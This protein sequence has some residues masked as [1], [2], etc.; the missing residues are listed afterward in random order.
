MTC[1]STAAL[2][3]AELIENYGR[4]VTSICRRMFRDEESARDAAQEV[5][6]EVV[7][8]LPS[9]RGDSKLS[10]WIYTIAYRVAMHHARRERTYST[11]FL[12]DF[13]RDGEW[14]LPDQKDFDKAVWVKQMCDRCLTGILHCL[15]NEARMAYIFRDVAGLSYE[16]IAGILGREPA[17]VR[18][19][20]S[21]SRRK[22]RHFLEDECALHKP[23][24][25]CACRMK[26]WVM[27][28][29]LPR[30]YAKLRT[31]AGRVNV[32]RESETVM[33][34]RNYWEQ[35]L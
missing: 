29:D 11:R 23:A 32:F 33:P 34:P 8:S 28:V 19:L 18:Q 31:M 5:W 10:T 21:R 14:E 26:R 2:S 13:F 35:Y 7:R 4:L 1:H 24:G 30:E 20:I 12:S 25:K 9:F 3:T 17:A 15:D 16:E 27:E 6:L 22:L